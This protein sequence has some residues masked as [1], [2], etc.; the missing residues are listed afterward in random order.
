MS[1]YVL[2]SEFPS[3]QLTH[4]CLGLWD[5]DGSGHCFPIG[6]F[7]G[8]SPMELRRHQDAFVLRCRGDVGERQGQW[9][10]L[11]ETLV[12]G[13]LEPQQPPPSQSLSPPHP[14]FSPT[15]AKVKA[16]GLPPLCS[17]RYLMFCR[18]SG[19]VTVLK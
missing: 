9:G 4:S 15:R 19:T 6:H 7:G 18:V 2:L 16:Q 10:I 14:A 3:S 1:D 13:R 8:W 12:V 5:C 17:K 11:W